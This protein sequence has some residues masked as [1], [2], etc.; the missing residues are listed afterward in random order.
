MKSG[1]VGRVLSRMRDLDFLG[2][3]SRVLSTVA[4][5]IAREFKGERDIVWDKTRGLLSF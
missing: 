4:L 1:A 3:K 2:Q 5:W